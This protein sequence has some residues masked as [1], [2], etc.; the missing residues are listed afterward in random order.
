MRG[1]CSLSKWKLM[2]LKA[3]SDGCNYL[4]CPVYNKARAFLVIAILFFASGVSVAEDLSP[5]SVATFNER[6]KVVQLQDGT[7]VAFFLHD[8]KGIQEV[9]TQVSNDNAKTWSPPQSLLQ[10]P[11]DPG[12]WAGPEALVDSQGE[13]HLFFLNDA[14]TGVIRTGE[15]QRPKVGQM[16][17][18]RLD[19]WHTKSINGRKSWQSP[20]RI[21]E[22]YTGALNSVI[23]LKGGRILLPFSFL[24][25]RRWSKR[26]EGLDSFTFMGQYDCT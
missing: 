8:S 11:Q 14:H 15:D 2:S 1:V 21:W 20:K 17:Q 3:G 26:G 16:G 19:I 10:L 25:R 6:P 7:F 5:R 24:T 12:N 23:Q 9:V 18:K 22:G 4:E 13:I